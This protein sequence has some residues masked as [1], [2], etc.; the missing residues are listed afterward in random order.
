M[1]FSDI[2]ENLSMVRKHGSQKPQHGLKNSAHWYIKNGA[3]FPSSF[4][5]HG[6]IHVSAHKN[7]L[8]LA[9][10]DRSLNV[11]TRK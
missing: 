10:G 9:V 8:P 4:L 2:L 7:K 3:Y 11:I 1:L 6:I 5:H